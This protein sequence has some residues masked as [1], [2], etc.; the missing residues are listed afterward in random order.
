[1]TTSI[2][3]AVRSWV[4]D[5]EAVHGPS[6]DEWFPAAFDWRGLCADAPD[7]AERLGTKFP[8]GTAAA[9]RAR[10][11][12]LGEAAF[13]GAY[14]TALAL[15][16]AYDAEAQPDDALARLTSPL[17]DEEAEALEP[18]LSDDLAA[19]EGG[20]G[21]EPLVD[22]STRV[23][24]ALAR[25][26]L[27]RDPVRLVLADGLE[28]SAR[29]VVVLGGS[30]KALAQVASG[31][32]SVAVALAALRH[33]VAGEVDAEEGRPAL[34]PDRIALLSALGEPDGEPDDE[35]DDEGEG[36]GEDD[37]D[38]PRQDDDGLDAR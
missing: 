31:L 8:E 3:K 30:A 28:A 34:R 37:F 36:A 1:V 11:E 17:S 2:P 25:A 7:I 6:M 12:E 26:R 14:V 10:F 29:G 9:V 15:L 21:G 18:S 13:R 19:V 24:A 33:V 16:A 32:V 35:P 20:L 38:D 23:R 5:A 22:A 4:A 27:V